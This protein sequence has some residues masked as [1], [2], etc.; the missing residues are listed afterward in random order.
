MEEVGLS[1]RVN[2]FDSGEG[3][4]LGYLATKSILKSGESITALFAGDDAAALG[5]YQAI[6]ESGLRVPGD[7]SVVGFK[8]TEAG[9]LPPP[10]PSVPGFNEQ[11]GRGM[12]ALA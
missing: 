3:E 7:I 9:L 8:D 2:E 4:D 11:R 5:A 1:P 10:L 6:H 12:A